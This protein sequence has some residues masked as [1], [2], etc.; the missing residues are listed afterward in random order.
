MIGKNMSGTHELTET[1]KFIWYYDPSCQVPPVLFLYVFHVFFPFW[2]AGVIIEF[3]T[4]SSQSADDHV[5]EI[6]CHKPNSYALLVGW[7]DV[8][9]W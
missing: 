4:G 2:F 7:F 5:I 8:T 6:S 3:D 9:F 1:M